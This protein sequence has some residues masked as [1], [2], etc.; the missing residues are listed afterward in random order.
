MKKACDKQP[1][2]AE[3]IGVASQDQGKGNQAKQKTESQKKK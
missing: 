2:K 3:K 1:E